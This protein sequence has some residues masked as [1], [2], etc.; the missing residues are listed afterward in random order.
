M[1][2]HSYKYS[3]GDKGIGWVISEFTFNKNNLFVGLS[4]SGKSRALNSL[5][6]VGNFVSTNT[7]RD[8]IWGI[9]FE[10]DGCMYVWSLHSEIQADE[11]VI[12]SEK[13]TLSKDGDPEQILFARTKDDFIFND[14]SLPK[15]P[16][17][18]TG[19]FLL[20]DEVLIKPV[21]A[22]FGRILRRNF[23]GSDLEEA[24]R[25]GKVHHESLN[26]DNYKQLAD[27]LMAG[28]IALNPR[29]FLLNKF[30]KDKFDAVK[31]EFKSIFS[32]IE[33]IIFVNPPYVF[34]DS[35]NIQV[36]AIKEKGIDAPIMLHDLSSGMQKVLLIITDLITLPSNWVYIID[37][38]ENS[39]GLNAI[40]FLPEFLDTYGQNSQF[41]ITSHHPYLINN[42][43]VSDWLIFSRSGSNVSVKSGKDLVEKYKESKQEAFI[44]LL[45]DP[46]YLGV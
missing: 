7:F 29:L 36:L 24:C 43:P 28:I 38:Y 10:I 4:G 31:G 33:D 5:W 23:F 2:L 39:L 25:V 1:F 11:Q 13:L 26:K 16:K 32:F 42:M 6:N 27:S 12:V 30:D 15:L 37:E 8:G 46:L 20:K 41:I 18:S 35:A 40:N 14:S 21:H 44:Q 17:N 9:R 45:N 3:D 22:G 19:I 34:A